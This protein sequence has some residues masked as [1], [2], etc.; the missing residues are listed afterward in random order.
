VY[1]QSFVLGEAN[2]LI[3]SFIHT[4]IHTNIH[5]YRHTHTLIC[6][7][8]CIC[9]YIYIYTIPNNCSHLFIEDN[10][11]DRIPANGALCEE[12]RKCWNGR[13]DVISGDLDEADDGVGEPGDHEGQDHEQDHQRRPPFLLDSKLSKRFAA[14]SDT[15][16][17]HALPG[18]TKWGSITVP[19]TSCLTGLD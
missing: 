1:T 18:N 11:D 4:Y 5:T 19:L 16:A 17:K 12:K 3:C 15:L 9:I 10:V 13:R 6:L 8:I 14:A 2:L 7:Y